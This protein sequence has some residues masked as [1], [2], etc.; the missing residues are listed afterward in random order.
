MRI[1]TSLPFLI[2]LLCLSSLTIHGQ[3]VVIPSYNDTYSNYIKKLE[4]GETDINYQEFRFSFIESEQFKIASKK[5]EE[6][7][8][9]EKAMYAQMKKHQY[10]DIIVTTKKMLTIDYTNMMAHKILRQ[11]YKILGDTINAAKYKTIQFGLLNS[12]VK[13]GDGRT[14]ETAWPVIQIEE[15]YFILNMVDA[16]FQKQSLDNDTGLCDK[17]ETLVDGKEKIYYFEV[18]KVFE[19]NKKILGK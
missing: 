9:L 18:T 8:K 11:T 1:S 2:F 4:A 6:F 15:E 19:G 12:I 7:D 5:S 10:N 13:N 3:E 14:C 16:V 17:M